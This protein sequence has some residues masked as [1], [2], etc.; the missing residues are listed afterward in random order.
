MNRKELLLISLMEE[1]SEVAQAASKCLRFSLDHRH[2]K[3]GIQNFEKLNTEV[4]DLMALLYSLEVETGRIF[5]KRVRSERLV[6][7]DFYMNISKEMGIFND[8]N[9]A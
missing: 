3:T 4:D 9:C 2:P 7:L 5:T 8:N 6:Q 1:C